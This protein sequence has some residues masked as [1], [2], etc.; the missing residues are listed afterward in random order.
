MHSKYSR[1]AFV[2]RC[3]GVRAFSPQMG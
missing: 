1:S 3:S 2:R